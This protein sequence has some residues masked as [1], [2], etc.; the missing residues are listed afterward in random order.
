VFVVLTKLN[1]NE[2][3]WGHCILLNQCI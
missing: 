1:E 3:K 2:I